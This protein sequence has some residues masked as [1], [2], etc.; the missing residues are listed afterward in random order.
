MKLFSSL[1]GLAAIAAVIPYK[2]EKEEDGKS[3][4][5][6]SLTWKVSH[7]AATETEESQTNIS[8][9]GGLNEAVQKVKQNLHKEAPATEADYCDCS[10]EP[11]CDCG[12]SDDPCDCGCETDGCDCKETDCEN[13]E[14]RDTECGCESAPSDDEP[15]AD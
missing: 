11:D 3:F 6:T 1:L 9:L 8:L 15:S 2:V 10:D 5:A 7:K 14:C 4:T 12:C 13:D